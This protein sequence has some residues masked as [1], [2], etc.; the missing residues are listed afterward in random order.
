[1][2]KE[3]IIQTNYKNTHFSSYLSK[4]T[5]NTM[6]FNP[7]TEDEVLEVIKNLDAKKSTG[8]DGFSK[9]IIKFKTLAAELSVPLTPIFNMSIKDGIVQDQLKTARVVPIHKNESKNNFTNYRPI[10]VLPAFSKILER[11]VFNTCIW[12]LNNHNILFEN[13]FGFHPKHSTNMA[14]IKL[15]D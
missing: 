9:L 8:H 4:S 5:D 12:F 13:Q 10:S 15:V 3:I 1:M 7:I 14:V 11:L 6:F 2:L